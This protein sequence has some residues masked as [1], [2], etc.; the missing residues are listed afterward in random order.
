MTV[1][2]F[3]TPLLLLA[4]LFCLPACAASTAQTSDTAATK[5]A[6]PAAELPASAVCPISKRSFKPS[7]GTTTSAYK[8][9]TVYFCC[10]GCKKRFDT[11]PDKVMAPAAPETPAAPA[12]QPAAPA[13]KPA[14]GDAGSN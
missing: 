8:G 3:I 7:A 10:G 5:A 1:R 12:Q 9:K 6:G 11:N 2:S 4:W 13:D 14:A